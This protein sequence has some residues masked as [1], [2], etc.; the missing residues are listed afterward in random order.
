VRA[1]QLLK[2]TAGDL[3]DTSH[4]ET[5][6]QAGNATTG[7]AKPQGANR[8][9]VDTQFGHLPPRKA[10][11]DAAGVSRETQRKLDFVRAT[12]DDLWEQYQRKEITISAAYNKAKEKPALTPNQVLTAMKKL[13]QT[14]GDWSSLQATYRD[15]VD[16]KI[17][18]VSGY[19][20]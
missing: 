3:I 19:F 13:E 10:R 2:E 7:K 16:G 18:G 5:V 6:T 9:T 8:F 11:A 15:L 20:C 12:R 17:K 1:R 4:G 14:W